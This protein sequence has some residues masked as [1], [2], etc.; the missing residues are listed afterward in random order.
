MEFSPSHIFPRLI[1]LAMD[2]NKTKRSEIFATYE[3]FATYN[4]ESSKNACCARFDLW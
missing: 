4:T 3:P 1:A 2:F